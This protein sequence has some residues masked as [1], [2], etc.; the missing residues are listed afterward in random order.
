MR[1]ISTRST[2]D[3]KNVNIQVA[4]VDPL[5]DVEELA[6]RPKSAFIYKG[7][8][9]TTSLLPSNDNEIGDVWQ[10]SADGS[11]WTW[12]GTTWEEFG[13]EDVAANTA[14]RHTH[15][16]KNI[17]DTVTEEDL[18]PSGGSNDDFLR[19]TANGAAW[20]TVPAAENNS[21]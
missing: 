12:N 17:L 15:G 10:V 1:T 8:V 18:L 11:E 13:S 3:G 4:V 20:Q 14:A 5:K 9:S 6:K 21:F 16:N 7:T 2:H 19:K